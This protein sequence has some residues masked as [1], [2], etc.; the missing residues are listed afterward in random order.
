[1]FVLA[2]TG[3]GALAAVYLVACLVALV[4]MVFVAG[5]YVGRLVFPLG[6]TM[7]R[8]G[9]D[10][11]VWYREKP[12]VASFPPLPKGATVS[13]TLAAVMGSRATWRAYGWLGLAILA[14]PLN[15][16]CVAAFFLAPLWARAWAVATVRLLGRPDAPTRRRAVA[17]AAADRRGTQYGSPDNQAES[18]GAETAAGLAG[19]G[20]VR[21]LVPGRRGYG[22]VGMRERV[23]AV[24]GTLVAGPTE[25]GGFALRAVLPLGAGGEADAGAHGAGASADKS[26]AGDDGGLEAEGL[27]GGGADGPGDEA[28]G[29]AAFYA[30][31]DHATGGER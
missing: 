20:P 10:L 15:L 16:V 2:Q 28:V 27:D 30:N 25:D 31:G 4:V 14:L 11:A 5:R 7:G 19:G 23:A 18:L 17:L 26:G 9:L 12:P 3:L 22:L 13:Q 21:G 24:G 29:E 8:G 6:R 1:V